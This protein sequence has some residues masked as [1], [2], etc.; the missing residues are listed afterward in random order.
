MSDD[1]RKESSAFVLA[2]DTSS[3]TTSIAIARGERVIESC[4]SSE[5]EARS[6]RLWDDVQRLLDRVGAN[7]GDVDL[8]AVSVGPGGFTGIRVGIAAVKGFALAAGKPIVGVTSLEAAA[9]EAGPSP[10]VAAMVNAYKSE[11]YTQ[12]FSFDDDGV[13]VAESEP[14]VLTMAEAVE[15]IKE[16][17][18]IVF[19]GDG[20]IAAEGIIKRVAGI[21][22][23]DVSGW[24]ISFSSESAASVARLAYRKYMRGESDTPESLRAC[25]VRQA[26]A[27]IKLSLGLLG[28]KI[29]RSISPQQ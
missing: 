5:S 16:I 1:L 21:R 17:D 26:E 15:R 10:M 19:A 24:R 14:F 2:L 28:S 27:E 11:V 18:D 22:F 8:Y 3:K 4:T 23:G 20:A 9:F 13:P 29:R 7:V 12:L 6:E 25:Y